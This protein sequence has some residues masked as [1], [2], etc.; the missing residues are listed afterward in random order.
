MSK[1]T[2]KEMIYEVTRKPENDN[3]N[4][5]RVEIYYSLGGVNYFT[6]KMEPRGWYF[7]IAPEYH[8]GNM[9]SYA[10]FSGM[11]TCILETKRRTDK[12]ARTA[13]AM[14]EECVEKYLKPWC[15]RNGYGYAE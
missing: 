3:S 1:T 6:Y 10:A 12:G 2:A 11:K 7:S 4:E 15:E 14:Y 13:A 8:K 9:R 5:L